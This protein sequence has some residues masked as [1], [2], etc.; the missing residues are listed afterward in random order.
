MSNDHRC[1]WRFSTAIP[2]TRHYVHASSSGVSLEIRK[3]CAECR[4]CKRLA[5]WYHAMVDGVWVR[6][7]FLASP[8]PMGG[9][10]FLFDPQ[11]H[12][13]AAYHEEARRYV[14]SVKTG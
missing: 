1:S 9:V 3:T 7:H 5:A 6:G 2:P 13:E 4:T 12:R 14:E 11:G 8:T 10:Y